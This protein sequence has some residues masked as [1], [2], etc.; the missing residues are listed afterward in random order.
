[1]LHRILASSVP[2][3]LETLGSETHSLQIPVE[4]IPSQ[5][6][7]QASHQ[8]Q[9]SMASPPAQG[10]NLPF[11]SDH[12]ELTPGMGSTPGGTGGAEDINIQA[13]LLDANS[14]LFKDEMPP[15]KKARAGGIHV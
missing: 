6:Q 12:S 10:S 4:Y 9:M 7:T 3:S 2:S 8:L 1:M 15:E 5:T 11:S 14:V 13:G